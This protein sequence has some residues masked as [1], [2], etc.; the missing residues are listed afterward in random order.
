MEN[1][2]NLRREAKDKEYENTEKEKFL[3][4]LEREINQKIDEFEEDK[5]K[6]NK[7]VEAKSKEIL[8]KAEAFKSESLNAKN[9]TRI[10]QQKEFEITE[11]LKIFEKNEAGLQKNLQKFESEIYDYDIKKR[12]YDLAKEEFDLYSNDVL[13][14]YE[15]IKNFKNNFDE[16]SKKLQQYELILNERNRE[17]IEKE[18]KLALMQSDIENK[19]KESGVKQQIIAEREKEI[20]DMKIL[21]QEKL[22][23]YNSK[24]N[25]AQRVQ[26]RLKEKENILTF[27][28]DIENEIDLK[29]SGLELNETINK[30]KIAVQH[31][32]L[33]EE[34]S[35]RLTIS[36]LA[37]KIVKG[38]TE[39][40]N[41][42]SANNKSNFSKLMTIIKGN[43]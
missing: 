28:S 29:L 1:V 15:E 3:L 38:S 13:T 9:L 34:I 27:K 14:K 35:K 11:K 32:M 37:K 18:R 22:V 40:S 41:N 30:K 31:K 10:F 16:Q 26:E 25:N 33:N 43:K 6:F 19:N 12:E 4:S 24:V 21:L 8:T 2:G 5:K 17:N 23:E 36:K 7:F 20:E 42:T 39:N